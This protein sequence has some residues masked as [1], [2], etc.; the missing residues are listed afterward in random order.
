VQWNPNGTVV[1]V[2]WERS[3]PAGETWPA[4]KKSWSK[5]IAAPNASRQFGDA[6]DFAIAEIVLRGSPVRIGK[7]ADVP[8]GGNARAE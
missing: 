4:V 3:V 6:L 1:R 7:R 8:Y 2:W 5:S